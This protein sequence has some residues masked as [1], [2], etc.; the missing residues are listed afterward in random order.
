MTRGYFVT[1]TDTGV[2]K[3]RVSLGLMSLLQTHGHVV[4]GMKPVASGCRLTPAGPVNEDALMLQA[5]ASFTVPYGDVNPYAFEPPVAPHLAA[6]ADGTHIEL[7][8]IEGAF[9]RVTEASDRVVV[10]GVGGWLVPISATRTMA[11][12]AVA[13][14]LPVVMVVAVRLGCINHAL[15]T[16]AAIE[17]AAVPFGGW[18]A[19]R[20]EPDGEA[21]EETIAA[22]RQWLGAP[23]LGAVKFATDDQSLAEQFGHIRL[24][25]C[26]GPVD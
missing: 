3:T 21:V 8:V 13:I 9:A 5:Q 6:Q 2:G 19:N 18:I 14:G 23:Y 20:T 4:T 11:D 16:A 26:L 7:D 24:E 25:N 15:L 10:E 12:V 1:G 17:A 22:L